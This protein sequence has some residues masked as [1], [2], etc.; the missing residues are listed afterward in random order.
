MTFVTGV[1]IGLGATIAL[2]VVVTLGILA[3][4]LKPLGWLI[5]IG[6]VLLVASNL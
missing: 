5:V 1:L 2:G 4:H 6:I 3:K